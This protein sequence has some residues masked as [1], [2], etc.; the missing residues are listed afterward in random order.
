MIMQSDQEL[1]PRS[2]P[3]W[4]NEIVTGDDDSSPTAIQVLAFVKERISS[5]DSAFRVIGTCDDPKEEE[6][7]CL[8]AYAAS[9]LAQELGDQAQEIM[10]TDGADSEEAANKLVDKF[11]TTL[12]PWTLTYALL[13]LLAKKRDE[14]MEGY[15]V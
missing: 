8:L 4:M 15:K 10:D 2:M 6:L 12:V 5:F 3:D 11:G 7:W 13:I 1:V 14:V 9:W